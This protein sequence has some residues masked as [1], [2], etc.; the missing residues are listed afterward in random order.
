MDNPRILDTIARVLDALGATQR[1]AHTMDCIEA[2]W[3]RARGPYVER[4]PHN[5]HLR[6]AHQVVQDQQETL[7]AVAGVLPLLDELGPALE[8]HASLGPFLA[9]ATDPGF[10]LRVFDAQHQP[11]TWCKGFQVRLGRFHTAKAAPCR[12]PRD[13]VLAT[14]ANALATAPTPAESITATEETI[15][16][17]VGQ[18]TVPLSVL[19]ALW[20]VFV[21]PAKPHLD[22]ERYGHL[23]GLWVALPDPHGAPHQGAVLIHNGADG[24]FSMRRWVDPEAPSDCGQYHGMVQAFVRT[25]CSALVHNAAAWVPHPSMPEGRILKPEM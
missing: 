10:A 11:G 13:H 6:S 1:F 14:L 8:G 15:G 9:S 17:M 3:S 22:A 16:S 7:A 12:H 2:G 20:P 4:V 25:L 19:D 5:G 24:D 21:R 23:M 18:G